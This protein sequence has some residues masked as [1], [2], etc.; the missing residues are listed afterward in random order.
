MT[1]D[2]GGTIAVMTVVGFVTVDSGVSVVFGL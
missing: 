1:T 2:S